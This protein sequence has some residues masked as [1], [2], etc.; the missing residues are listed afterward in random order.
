MTALQAQL[1]EEFRSVVGDS[2]D[3][4]TASFYLEIAE[5]DLQTAVHAYF[6]SLQAPGQQPTQPQRQQPQQQQPQPQRQQPSPL[7]AL[8]KVE[9]EVDEFESKLNTL[10]ANS[11]TRDVTA[12]A[13]WNKD[14]LGY[15]E[16]LMQKL[17]QLDSIT[18]DEQIRA[19]RRQV[20]VRTQQLMSAFEGLTVSA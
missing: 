13:K 17:E 18:G 20:I 4:P 8:E 19:K 10:R 16:L 15:T 7:A 6:E 2:V 14:I 5:W 9:K 12:T 11:F 3:V 1:I